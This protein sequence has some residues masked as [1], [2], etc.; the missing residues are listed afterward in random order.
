MIE[1]G[2]QAPDFTL[3]VTGGGTLRLAA[4]APKQVVLFFYPKDDTPSCTTE[5]VDFSARAKAFARAGAKLVG[6]S[7]DSP[8]RHDNFR[9]K[10]G[11][12]VTLVSDAESDTCERYGVWGDKVLFG[13]AYQGIIR[14]TVLI[15]GDGRVR[16]VWSPV[17]VAG[18]VDEVLAAVKAA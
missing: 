1:I 7:K 13:R 11:L 18:H 15:G 14:T 4:L 6:I 3:P 2:E 5:A 16:R 9:K 17:R 12:T 8:R 10:H